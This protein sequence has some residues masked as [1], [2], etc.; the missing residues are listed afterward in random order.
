[1]YIPLY[2]TSLA[3]IYGNFELILPVKYLPNRIGDIQNIYPNHILLSKHKWIKDCKVVVFGNTAM[4]KIANCDVSIELN[5]IDEKDLIKLDDNFYL[6]DKPILLSQVKHIWFFDKD[7]MRLSVGN[8]ELTQGFVPEHL[9]KID[10]NPQ[11]VKFNKPKKRIPKPK[12]FSK[13]LTLYDK[14]LGAIILIRS[15]IGGKDYQSLLS[16]FDKNREQVDSNILTF[17]T[18]DPKWNPIKKIILK[19]SVEIEDVKKMAE[20]ENVKLDFFLGLLNGETIPINT[21]TYTF[22]TLYFYRPLVDTKLPGFLREIDADIKKSN[23]ERYKS[24]LFLYGIMVGYSLV[25]F[26]IYGKDKTFCNRFKFENDD[27]DIIE[28][29]YKTVFK[30][31]IPRKE[32]LLEIGKMDLE[33]I[34]IS[35]LAQKYQVSEQT[36]RK[37]IREVFKIGKIR[38]E[39]YIK[40]KKLKQLLTE[41]KLSTQDISEKLA[42]SKNTTRKY[43]KELEANKQRNGRIILYSL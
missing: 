36:I 3:H 23:F 39:K 33:Q 1:M 17:L 8:I 9:L 27:L 35:E 22:A 15:F 24:F 2:S 37:D 31:K 38:I 26:K 21:R 6:Y 28:S 34:N 7:Q 30:E 5:E 10:E 43:L 29:V 12:D 19:R 11:F 4:N 32:R 25:D 16:F 18:G 14:Y 20:I 40:L 13:Q 42:I 41:S